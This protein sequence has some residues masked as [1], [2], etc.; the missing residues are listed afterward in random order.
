MC[1][2]TW[3]K[4]QE[5]LDERA[6]GVDFALK[7]TK[8]KSNRVTWDEPKLGSMEGCGCLK[9]MKTRTRFSARTLYSSHDQCH[10]LLLPGVSMFLNWAE[11]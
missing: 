3:K 7:C 2:A 5:E 8:S 6:K 11:R 9:H 10:L 4:S 1:A